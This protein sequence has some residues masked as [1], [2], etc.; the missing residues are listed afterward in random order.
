MFAKLMHETLVTY[1]KD[2]LHLCPSTMW[3]TVHAHIPILVSIRLDIRLWLSDSNLAIHDRLTIQDERH[4]HKCCI[5]TEK[6]E[7][8]HHPPIHLGPSCIMMTTRMQNKVNSFILNVTTTV[9]ARGSSSMSNN[10][11]IQARCF[12]GRVHQLGTCTSLSWSSR[13]IRYIKSWFETSSVSV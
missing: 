1:A 4:I 8:F 13:N 10:Q 12:R 7:S 9:L 5:A 11:R 2:F 6:I 3:A